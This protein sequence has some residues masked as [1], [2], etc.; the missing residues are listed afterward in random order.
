MLK[1]PVALVVFNRP[2][3]TELVFRTIAR[4][5][6]R[7]LFVVADG[8]RS[9][10]E[11]EL[12][13]QTRAVVERVDWDCD[14]RINFSDVN[15]GPRRRCSSGFDW[16]FSQVES[17]ILLEDD[18][19]PDPTFFRFCEEMLECYRDDRRVMMITGSNYLRTWKAD[20]QSYHFSYFGSPWG[21]ASWRRAWAFYDDL[22][23]AWGDE[24]VKRRI[25]DFLA[26][27]E[28]FTFQAPRFDAVYAD[29][30]GRR[31]WDLR[32][33]FARLAQGGLTVVPAVN[34]ISNR[35]CLG[36]TSLPPTHPLANLPTAPITFPLWP[37]TS[38][39]VD[40]LYDKQHVRRIYE[41][42]R[43]Q[44]GGQ[45]RTSGGPDGRRGSLYD[46]IT[47]KVRGGVTDMLKAM[48]A[49]R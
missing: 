37:P 23:K 30:G 32:W 49:T 17:A 25:R 40:H 26:D 19:V 6:P 18:C 1:T 29:A 7:L 13:R 38:V 14:V 42:Y 36:G 46:R 39:A 44:A 33:H 16:V 3:L 20:T 31:S 35:G 4:A 12:C 41:W 11:A 5:R 22:M 34:L 9:S 8:P 10:E 21:W 27:D 43:L 15:L 48:G 2:H 24:D 28:C 47:R 45:G